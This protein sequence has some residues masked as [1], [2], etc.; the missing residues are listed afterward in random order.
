MN[1]KFIKLFFVLIFALAFA[2]CNSSQTA[3]NDTPTEAY[4]RLF[5]AVKSKNTEAIKKEMSSTTQQFATAMAQMQKKTEE[6]M[7]KNGLL[8][9]TMSPNLP[10]MRDQRIAGDYA[11]LE[12]QNP[13]GNWQ[14]VPFVKENGVWKIAVGDLFQGSYKSPGTPASRANS[15]PAMTDLPLES[16]TNP[17]ANGKSAPVNPSGNVNANTAKDKTGKEKADS[18]AAPKPNQQ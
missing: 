4:K 7:Y 3:G 2:A 12:V 10:Q 6:D 17:I 8:E 13:D 5:N 14:D 1:P 18:K 11:A 9:S 16:N 15:N